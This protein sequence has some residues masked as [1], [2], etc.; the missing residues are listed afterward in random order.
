MILLGLL[1]KP[2]TGRDRIAK[3]LVTAHNWAQYRMCGPAREMSELLGLFPEQFEPA[4]RNYA[5]FGNKT[6]NWLEASLMG[7]GTEQWPDI[8]RALA[9]REIFQLVEQSKVWGDQNVRPGVVI[10]DCTEADADW[11]RS[12][13]GVVWH[14]ESI[15]VN[16]GTPDTNVK[17]YVDDETI[18]LTNPGQ[19]VAPLVDNVLPDLLARFVAT[20]AISTQEAA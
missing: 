11:I 7:W 15:D 4:H 1:G 2:G 6:P 12:Q 19:D 10:S 13:G 20:S 8:W 5:V 9:A 16:V 3:H 18:V 17:H 14:T